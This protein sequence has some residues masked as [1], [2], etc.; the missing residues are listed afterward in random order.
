MFCR[1]LHNCGLKMSQFS[2]GTYFSISDRL[3]YEQSEKIV[4]RALSI[5]IN[6]ID[7]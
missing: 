6:F 4:N 3:N 7:L 2:L 1:K 5:G